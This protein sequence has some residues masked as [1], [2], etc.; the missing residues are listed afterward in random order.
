[1]KKKM[2]VVLLVVFMILSLTGCGAAGSKSAADAPGAS[3]GDGAAS[4]GQDSGFF[5]MKE[6]IAE[7]DAA[8]MP[9]DDAADAPAGEPEAPEPNGESGE[10]DASENTSK[11]NE[12]IIY[13]YNYS[14]E[15]KT[16]D[17]FMKSVEKRVNEYGG[18]MESSEVQGNEEMNIRR[19]ANLVIRIPAEK[20][21]DFLHMVE[22]SANVTYSTSS[23]ENVTLTYVDMKSHVEALKVEQQSLMDMLAH[24]DTVEAII[25]IQSRLTDVRYE[26]E[27]YESQLR[28]YD[29]RINY[30]TLYLDINE[31]DRE[32]SVATKLTYG[33]EISRGLSNTMYGMGQGLRDFSIWFIVNLPI[34][35]ILALVIV[36][37]VLIVR[38]VAKRSAR[39]NAEYIAARDASRL[40]WS[41]GAGKK[42]KEE[43]KEEKEDKKEEKEDDK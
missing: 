15:T 33:E 20:M 14:V 4:A 7:D 35:L 17:D 12:K 28:V 11:S 27:S 1:M 6:E 19:Y 29:N 32:S 2:C 42:E 21:P 18:Y 13:T 43:K 22:G 8:D 39:K 10:A 40:N 5:D 25:T 38:A 16:F 30:S 34:L 26:L 9:A 41:L 37:I 31:V 36:V 3:K 24:A 23:S